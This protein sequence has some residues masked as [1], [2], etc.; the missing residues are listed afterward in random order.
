MTSDL[1]PPEVQ[2]LLRTVEMFEAITE[3]QPDDYQSLEILKEAYNKLSRKEDTLRIAKKLAAA[4]V[5]LGQI[6]QAILEYEGVLQE[7]PDDADARAALTEL[8]S[9]TSNLSPLRKAGAPSLDQDSKPT[10]PAGATAGVLSF[11]TAHG[12]EDGDQQLAN[13]LI[14]EKIIST[15]AVLPLLK[16]LK[17]E[18]PASAERGQPLT[19]LQLLHDE[20]ILKLEELLATLVDN[21]GLPYVPLSIYDVD[22][23][24]VCL[25]PKEVCFT[26][27]IVPFDLISRSVLIATPNPFDLTTRD[28]VQA[29]IDYN[30]FWYVGSPTEI[31]AALRK[32]HQLETSGR[33]DLAKVSQGKA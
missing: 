3:S 29:M 25:L 7:S 6:S 2:Q 8:E 27:C 32:A 22:R 21:S 15:Q 24:V 10:S 12:T 33:P 19:L 31:V 9:K 20:Q 26:H 28:Q 14:A 18:G 13:L 17:T 5:S 30:T 4:Y 16:R 1:P 11:S 23:D